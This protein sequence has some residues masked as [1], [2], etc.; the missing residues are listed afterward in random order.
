MDQ[1]DPGRLARML[2][3]V[4]IILGWTVPGVAAPPAP[5]V[6]EGAG[7]HPS[8]SKDAIP[9]LSKHCYAC[10]GDGK[11]KGDLSL[12]SDRDEQAVEKNRKVWENVLEM[13]RA[14]EMPPKNRPRPSTEE[15][16]VA[17]LAIDGVLNRLDCSQT[18]NVGRVTLRR[19]NRVEYNNTIRD[20][21][22]VDFKPA[23]DFPNDD[24]GY[25]FDN[26]GDVLSLSPLLFEKYLTA[27]ETI[28]EQAIVTDTTP[29]PT[30][31]QLG[32]IRETEG[33]GGEK[34]GFGR[35]LHSIGSFRAQ[36]YFDEGDYKLRVSAFGQQV[37]DQPVRAI[38]RINGEDIQE[39]DVTG[40]RSSP[41]K[42][43]QQV[44]IKAGTK[45]F[46]VTF[47]NPYTDP[48]NS[49]SDKNRR[50]LF[51]SG[52]EL[53]G[54]YNS[55]PPVFPE[56]HRRIMAHQPGL[57]AREAAREIVTRF[58]ARAFRR[59]VQ[60]G[61]VDRLMK[62][63]DKA[64]LEGERFE[65]CVRLVLEGVLVWPDFL[66]R[67]ELDPRDAQPGTSYPVSEYELAS[68][69]SYFLWSSMPDETLLTLAAEGRLRAELEN[70]LRRMLKDP[71][72]AAFVEN[73]AG[74]WL[75]I[76]KLAYVAP[77]AKEFPG[78]DEDLRSAMYRETELFFE[79]IVR[80]DR[81][82]LD[83]LD[84]DYS[85]VNER[86]AKHYGMPGIEGKEFR[87]VKLP[88][89]RGGILTHASILTLTSN[90]T[91]TSPVKRG[92]WVLD[93]L[94]NTPPPPPPPDVP[95]F[96]EDKRLTGS[97]RKVME[98]HREK[99]LCASCHQR[100]DPIGFAFENY[101]A[102]GA[103]RDKDGT[104]LIDPSGA[105]PDGRSFQGPAELK[106]ILRGKKE[107]FSRCLAEKMLT[108]AMGRGLEYYDKCAVDKI[109]EALNQNG[110][111]LSVL[112]AEVVKSEP[113]QMR[114]ATG[115]ER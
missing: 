108:Y 49:D 95:E 9:F 97:L 18:R 32:G 53:D 64:E 71:K 92:K 34:R 101:D 27:A 20:L 7:T 35:F 96:P 48:K 110:D 1:C 23:A 6:G 46:A 45:T 72:S 36:G 28:L 22:G 114:T 15:V 100:M 75:T 87:R 66:F 59:P 42:I 88:A 81:S 38:L 74:Q 78:F 99:P 107:L 8:F 26:I 51:L 79:S 69:L 60:P 3:A 90:P 68:R 85:F 91:R 106:T 2:G 77:D 25:G 5:A 84:A 57:P 103:W 33:A 43:E 63:Y 29:T 105:L 93:Q 98:M 86:L 55:P 40:D 102:T 12:D 94:L 44:R 73:F 50:L 19:L 83:F 52:I 58:A 80:E 4:I 13:I 30:K 21:V 54:P 113:F 112:M 14:G 37:G 109:L 61:E 47:L 111:R 10:H 89:N 11:Q 56:T 65:D 62:L 24:V 31:S 67:I 115:E 82:I 17:L 41:T 16:E 104:F 70:E 39:F 76:R